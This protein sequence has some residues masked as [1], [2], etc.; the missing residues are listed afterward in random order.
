MRGSDY[1]YL[2]YFRDNTT[3]LQLKMLREYLC[4]E[5]Q[6]CENYPKVNRESV[7]RRDESIKKYNTVEHMPIE[8]KITRKRGTLYYH[9]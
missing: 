6:I 5:P 2:N 4:E 9:D 3:R 7:K 1:R 8:K